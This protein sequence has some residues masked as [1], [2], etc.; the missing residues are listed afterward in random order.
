MHA[1]VSVY[2]LIFLLRF[3][4]GFTELSEIC[5][6]NGHRKLRTLQDII[7]SLEQLAGT[8]QSG[9]RVSDLF[10]YQSMVDPFTYS[11]LPSSSA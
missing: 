1:D 11:Q 7:S 8:R 3:D 4:Y 5:N 2:P 9:K 6:A 10:Q